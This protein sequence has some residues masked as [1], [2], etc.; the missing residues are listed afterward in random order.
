[1]GKRDSGEVTETAMAAKTK[2]LKDAPARETAPKKKP[3]K[4]QS[5]D[6]K[7]KPTGLAVAEFIAGIANECRRNDAKAALK[8]MKKATGLQPKMW[9][10]SIIGFGSYHYNYESGREGD[11]CMTGFSPRAAGLV[12][13]LMGS[14][15]ETDPLYKTLGKYKTN[16]GC[17][18]IN[19]LDDIDLRVL[20]K[21]NARAV[22]H[23]RENYPTTN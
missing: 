7:T 14:K 17:L 20:E 4:K 3:A 6:L 11:M 8:Q 5:V 21:I 15:P 10:P 22:A 16:K 19:K 23:M 18:Y 9:G 12:F 1:L 13:Y 2:P